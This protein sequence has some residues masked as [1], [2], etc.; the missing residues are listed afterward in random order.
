MVIETP[1]RTCTHDVVI[2]H[3][4]ADVV[5]SRVLACAVF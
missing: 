5:A 2:S 3:G 1:S 4:Q